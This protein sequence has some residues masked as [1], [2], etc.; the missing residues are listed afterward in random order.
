MYCQGKY[1]RDDDHGGSDENFSLKYYLEAGK[2]EKAHEALRYGAEILAG[3][4]VDILERPELLSEIQTEAEGKRRILL[5]INE[6]IAE[7]PLAR[8]LFFVKTVSADNL[9]RGIIFR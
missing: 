6:K 5:K 8:P 9:I 7:A 4:C 1:L 2:T 3:T